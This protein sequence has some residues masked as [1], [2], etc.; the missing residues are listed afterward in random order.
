[1]LLVGAVVAAGEGLLAGVVL[2]VGA[3]LPQAAMNNITRMLLTG[4]KKRLKN[5]ACSLSNKVIIHRTLRAWYSS[6]C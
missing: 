1:M 2:L 3:E 5:I 4:K 6:V